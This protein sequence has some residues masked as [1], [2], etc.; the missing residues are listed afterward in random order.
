MANKMCN[1]NV[2]LI[3]NNINAFLQI[4]SNDLQPLSAVLIRS[5]AEYFYDDFII[6]P[7]EVERELSNINVNK[8]SGPDNISN[9][10][11]RDNS[12]WLAEP[13]CAIYNASL[14]EGCSRCVEA[15]LSLTY[16]QFR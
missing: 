8:A 2:Q 4:V 14:R 7:F 5:I 6:E 13:V 9:W 15:S 16:V 3:A 11:L 1:G 10:L 12:V